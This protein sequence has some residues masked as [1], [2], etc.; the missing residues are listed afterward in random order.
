MLSRAGLMAIT[1]AASTVLSSNALA[2]TAK[3]AAP[4][5]T[6]DKV[7]VVATRT[8]ESTFDVPS[9]VS[10]VDTD[11]ASLA[12][13]TTYTD[14][15]DNTPAVQFSGS[16]RRNG[17]MPNLRGYDSNGVLVLVDGARQNFQSEHDG[18]F[19]ID[20]NI[21][22][23]VEVVRGAGSSLYGSGAVG[24]VLAFETK[25]AA[26]LLKPGQTVGAQLTSG[27]ESAS[28][29]WNNN[30]SVYGRVGGVDLL[31]NGTF[32]KSD[33]IR[34]GDGTDLR[35]DDKLLNGFVKAGYTF[36]DYH[37]IKASFG[38]YNNDSTEPNNPQGSATGAVETQLVDKQSFSTNSRVAYSYD[39]PD[40]TL[41]KLKAQVYYNNTDVEEKVLVAT[42]TNAAGDVLDRTLD[43][44]GF[45][46]DNQS[47]FRKGKQ[48]GH[49]FSYGVDY[50]KDTQEGSDSARGT[51]GGVPNAD[52]TTMGAYIQDEIGFTDLGM[53]AGTLTITPG[54]RFDS[55]KSDTNGSD[56]DDT[57]S[58][59]KISAAYKPNDWFMTFAS[60]AEA[61]RAPNLTELYE[62]GR[63][64]A[65]GPYVNN[66]VPNPGL[67]PETSKTFEYGFGLNFKDVLEKKDAVQF[68]LS[69]YSTDAED[70]I[71]P[72]VTGFNITG[73]CFGPGAPA[74][75]SAGST[76]I[77]NLPSA[78]LWGVDA[79][80]AYE[81]QRIRLGIGYAQI[82]GKDDTTGAAIDSLQPATVSTNLT[83]KLPEIDSATGVRVSA[84]RAQNHVTDPMYIRDGYV[85]TDVY[86]RYAPT[87]KTL[88]NF[89]FDVGVDN[90]FDN[91]YERV[92]AGALETGRNYK[93][94]VRYTW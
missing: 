79:E 89:T 27:F 28:T 83:V 19:F 70:Y 61:F 7:T 48:F 13:A 2:A 8:A 31:A 16:S 40:D 1:L 87:T 60:Y 41:L 14:L 47:S 74:S 57:A 52:G 76:Q 33:D 20:P 42:S 63:H 75:C 72:Q 38:A 64:F 51:R 30:A 67:K 94:Q 82:N 92:F 23:Q 81:N 71:F 17:Q 91:E 93:V 35:S 58:S 77:S 73:A 50:Y 22:K 3:A 15:F 84:A 24:G 25:D 45:N 56:N 88:E 9:M 36:N 44:I 26:D 80:A 39:N 5:T 29:E 68:K 32:L 54:I 43:T 85:T 37:T 21:V 59:P 34:L 65:V 90:V 49:I 46:I 11:D 69:R 10:V 55:Y 18:R 4:I 66:F 12:G 53:V 86:Y 6:L 62:N 78:S